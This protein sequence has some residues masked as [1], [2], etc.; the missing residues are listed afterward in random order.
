MKYQNYN[1]HRVLKTSEIALE[2]RNLY[3]ILGKRQRA[4]KIHIGVIIIKKKI[5]ITNL[6]SLVDKF[7]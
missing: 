3:T 6:Q 1:L 2:W 7:L 5:F 4:K